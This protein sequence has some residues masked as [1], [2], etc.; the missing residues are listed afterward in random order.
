MTPPKPND[1]DAML[2]MRI[3]TGDKEAFFKLVEVY[4]R[5][6]L[7]FIRRILED[8]SES[9]D[10]LQTTWLRVFRSIC[11]L[12]EPRALRVW[13]YRIAHDTAVSSLRI[14]IRRADP[15]FEAEL[16]DVE[17]E[18]PNVERLVDNVELVHAALKQLSFDHRRVLT[19]AFLESM[20]VR[21]IAEVLN[22]KTG[23][24]KS[25]LYYAR[26]AFRELVKESIHD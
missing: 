21:E 6:L 10:A 9:L 11:R 7:Y 5:K 19:L 24:V 1:E 26:Q 17:D 13:L 2:V 25:R 23:T 15:P 16:L 22:C 20:S 18:S 14:K 8:E 3:Q 4:E 12:K